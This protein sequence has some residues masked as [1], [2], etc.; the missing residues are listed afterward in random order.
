MP[1]LERF[2]PD[3]VC[4]ALDLPGHG[5]SRHVPWT[6]LDAVADAVAASITRAVERPV[7][8]VGFSAGADVG[9]RL[10]ARAPQMIAA[11]IL[12]G[13]STLPVPRLERWVD[14]LTWPVIATPV[15]HRLLTAQMG[16]P[17]QLAA[18]QREGSRPLRMRDY[19]RLSTEVLK[20]ASLDGLATQR[21]PVLAIAGRH[22]S[23]HARR[24]AVRLVSVLPGRAVAALAPAGGHLWHVHEPTLFSE[25]V[26]R[27]STEPGELHAGLR[28]LGTS[29]A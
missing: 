5:A 17:P 18:R 13:V 28:K 3:R 12:T 7:V 21:A 23:R 22:E 29:G 11:A 4:L 27:W 24:S 9:V 25:V 8:L 26:E 6:S 14:R 2:S 20:G 10:L 15:A 16:L 19:A 1:Q